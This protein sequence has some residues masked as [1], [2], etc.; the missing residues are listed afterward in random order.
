[1]DEKYFI[2]YSFEDEEKCFFNEAGFFR[3]Q[4]VSL[5]FGH[6]Y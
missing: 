1:M 4:T 5:S 2:F 6:F 3:D